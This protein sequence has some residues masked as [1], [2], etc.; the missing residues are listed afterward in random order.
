MQRTFDR[1]WANFT[2]RRDTGDWYDYTPYEWRTVGTM[3]RLKHPERAWAIID[4]FFGHRRPVGFR[5]WAEVVFRDPTTPRFIGDMPHTWVGTDFLRSALDL[6]GF[7]DE[8]ARTLVVGAGL[9]PEWLGPGVAIR[10][11][12]TWYGPLTFRAQR[13]AVGRVEVTF[14][15]GAHPPGGLVLRIPGPWRRAEADGQ[16]VAVW[17][18]GEVRVPA[19]TRHVMLLEE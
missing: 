11:L 3:L 17:P 1:Y 9:R 15:P 5:H 8:A 12:K 16:P 2:R 10:D 7:E 13:T 14:E 6:F 19:A 18:D 4:W